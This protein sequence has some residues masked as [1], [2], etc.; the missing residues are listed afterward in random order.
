MCNFFRKRNWTVLFKEYDAQGKLLL[1]YSHQ[2]LARTHAGALREARSHLDFLNDPFASATPEP[3][4]VYAT[5]P[6]TS[7]V[8]LGVR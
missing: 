2:V 5:V 6:L 4:G 7:P 3:R 8:F 1:E